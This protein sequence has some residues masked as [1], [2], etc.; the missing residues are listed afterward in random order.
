MFL[1][2][3][4]APRFMTYGITGNPYKDE[5]WPAVAELLGWLHSRDLGYCLDTHIAEGLDRRGLVDTATC[6]REAVSDL[7]RHCDIVLSFGGDGTMLRSVADVGDAATPILGVN[8]GRLGFLAK[9]EVNDLAV[10]L[11]QV[12]AGRYATEERLLLE[13]TLHHPDA[14]PETFVAM[15]DFVIDKSGSTSMI[16]VEATVD[17]LFLNTY[18]ADGLIVA[19]PTGSTAYS[20]SAGGPIITPGSG[21]V[22]LTPIAAH[23]L[24]ARPIILPDSCHVELQ[25]SARG[26]G[27]VVAAD[28]Q[29]ERPGTDG[30]RITIRKADYVAHLVTLPGQTYFKTL[31]SKLMWG[32]GRRHRGGSTR[33]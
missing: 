33:D 12:E 15:N 8:I 30:L 14:S 7:A 9:V 10:A 5:L 22:V 17:G 1:R 3:S 26:G 32:Q 28:G 6:R 21:V 18:W 24:T 25:V 2:D 20:L 11:E 23:T 27:Y 4:P 31:R 29:T 13:A 16:E 19:T